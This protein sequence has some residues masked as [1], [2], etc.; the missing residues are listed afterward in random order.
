MWDIEH[1]NAVSDTR[2]DDDRRDSD[3]NNRLQWLKKATDIPEI[4]KIVTADG[5]PVLPLIHTITDNKYYLAKYQENTRDFIQVYEAVINYFG[6]AGEADHSIG[7]LTLLDSSTNR[8]YKND[9]FPLKRK[10][11]LERTLSDVFIPLCTR[12]V[13]MKGFAESGDLLRWREV[14]KK[15]YTEEIINCICNYLKLEDA[16]NEQ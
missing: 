14:D 4:E 12:K 3:D 9:V 1:N 2:P 15:A 8:S 10:T 7:N 13:F 11:I 5:Q 16:D 6:G